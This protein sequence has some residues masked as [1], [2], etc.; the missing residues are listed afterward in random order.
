MAK[1]IDKKEI[2][3]KVVPSIIK[4]ARVT[5][6][7]ANLSAV[8]IYIFD[9]AVGATKPEIAKAFFAKYKTKA[10]KVNTSNRK[11]KALFRRGKLGFTS[12]TQ[13]AYITVAKGAK[14]DIV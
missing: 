6:K 3:E 7:A 2:K 12:R 9:V 13:K 11:A 10:I 1:K 4:K 8:N 14:V 5:E